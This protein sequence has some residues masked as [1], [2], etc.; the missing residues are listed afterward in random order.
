MRTRQKIAVIAIFLLGAFTTLTGIVRLH[1]LSYAYASLGNEGLSD[2]SCQR[3]DPHPLHAKRADSNGDTDDFAPAFYWSMIETN[4]GVISACL[5]TLRPVVKAYPITVSFPN[6]VKAYPIKSSFSNLVK[7]ATSSFGFAARS[8]KTTIRLN[9]MEH[10]MEQGLNKSQSGSMDIDGSKAHA[11]YD[12]RQA[13]PLS[14]TAIHN[15]STIT[16]PENP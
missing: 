2:S 10:S 4:A 11:M 9:S 7:V 3:Q 6:W 14:S 1:F 16:V 5:P 13:R 12:S 15:P 8:S